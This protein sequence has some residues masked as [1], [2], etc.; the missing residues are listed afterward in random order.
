MQETMEYGWAPSVLDGT[1]SEFMHDGSLDM[2]EAYDYKEY[3]SRV[4]NQGNY[5]I[6]VACSVGAHLNWNMNVDSKNDNSLDNGIRLMDIY[7]SKTTN[8][9]GM[10]FKDALH[11][12][13]HTGVM[14]NNGLMKIE[15]YAMVSSVDALKAALVLNGPCIGGMIVKNFTD[16]FW[17]SKYGNGNYGGHAICISG[18]NKHGF[19][20]RNSWGEEWGKNGYSVLPYDQFHLLLEIWTIID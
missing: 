19:I 6:C 12:L 17:D 7:K 1:E 4:Y 18:Y 11:F 16:K 8:G 9:N 14:S 2:P 5:P 20:I 13:R 15:R 3:L 10:T